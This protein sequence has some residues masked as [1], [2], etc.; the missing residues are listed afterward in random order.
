MRHADYYNTNQLIAANFNFLK[1]VI[2]N[3]FSIV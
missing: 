2:D 1:L 3:W